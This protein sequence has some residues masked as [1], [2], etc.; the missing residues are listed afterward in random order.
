VVNLKNEQSRITN[1]LQVAQQRVAELEAQLAHS[2][3]PLNDHD[4]IPHQSGSGST[5]PHPPA[6]V[7]R[8][9]TGFAQTILGIDQAQADLEAAQSSNQWQ[10]LPSLDILQMSARTFFDA[11]HINYPFLNRGELMV[12]LQD[13]WSLEQGSGVAS[14]GQ[15]REFV[16]SMVTSVGAHLSEQKGEI[17]VGTAQGLRERAMRNLGVATSK[18]DLVSS[19]PSALAIK[20]MDTDNSTSLPSPPL[21]R[22]TRPSARYLPAQRPRTRCPDGNQS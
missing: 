3:A 9:Y 16:V 2:T 8:Y 18:S 13:M 5:F 11:C 17:E 7:E 15:R 22:S 19:L 6:E 12:D 10:P 14:V 4:Q 1:D 20:L 21:F